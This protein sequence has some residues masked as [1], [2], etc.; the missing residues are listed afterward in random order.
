MGLVLYTNY[1][2]QKENRR[3]LQNQMTEFSK[4][5][6]DLSDK[7]VGQLEE[8]ADLTASEF[9]IRVKLQNEVLN[10]AETR[11]EL[12]AKHEEYGALKQTLDGQL[13]TQR[14][15]QAEVNQKLDERFQQEETRYQKIQEFLNVHKRSL[16]TAQKQLG[17][18]QDDLSRLSNET[19]A[20]QKTQSSMLAK[21]NNNQQILERKNQ[22]LAKKIETLTRNQ[23]SF[24]QDL[25][26]IKTQVDSLY[27]WRK[28]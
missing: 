18:L 24:Q 8:K 3:E 16:Q 2:R 6:S 11:E 7:L 21:V 25:N 17:A 9:E 28:K 23:A 13:A 19:T 22:D 14:K 5:L 15:Y 4:R 27:T 10:H 12:D 20:L 26:A 1:E